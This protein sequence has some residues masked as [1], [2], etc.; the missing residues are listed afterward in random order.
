MNK[1]RL[2]ITK[3]SPQRNKRYKRL[4]IY[5]L[6]GLIFA[7]AWVVTALWA[8][9]QSI[10]EGVE[11]EKDRDSNTAV[12]VSIPRSPLQDGIHLFGQAQEPGKFQTEYLIFEMKHSQVIGAF[13]MPSSSF[14]CFAGNL[15]G[16]TLTLS[17]VESY[18]QQTYEHS[19]NL[20]QYYAIKQINNNDLRILDVCSVHSGHTAQEP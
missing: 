5:L 15:K 8:Q 12:A 19:V 2:G 11:Q 3:S 6:S 18:E 14:D 10:F 16:G 7:N 4:P 17:V 13:F 1:L 9:A 20:N